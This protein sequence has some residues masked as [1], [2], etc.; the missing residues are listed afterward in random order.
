MQELFTSE[1]LSLVTLPNEMSH[2]ESKPASASFFNFNQ[3]SYDSR[4]LSENLDD[5]ELLPFSRDIPHAKKY[6][7]DDYGLRL[8]S[9]QRGEFAQKYLFK[10]GLRSNSF[11]V[12]SD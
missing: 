11:A 1:P 6:Q 7:E 5:P 2:Q 4:E 3:V 12:F 8:S 9:I 10:S